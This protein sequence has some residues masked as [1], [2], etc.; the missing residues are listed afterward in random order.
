M[1]G[2]VWAAGLALAGLIGCQSTQPAAGVSHLPTPKLM[3]PAAG[4]ATVSRAVTTTPDS[5]KKEPIKPATL[6]ALGNYRDHLAANPDLSFAEAEQVRSMARAAYNEALKLDPK[7]TAAYLG[8]AKSY[9]AIEDA[10]QAYAMYEKALQQVPE[11]ASLWYEKGL[12]HARFKD[13]P[14]ALAS[15]KR[16]SQIDPDNRLY[17][18]TIG[19]THARMG[20]FEDAY[21]A[22]RGC[23]KEEEVMYTLAR[24]ACH[25]D[26]P[27]V[28]REYL[29]L[30]LKAHPTFMP[31]H[32]MINELN[33]GGRGTGDVTQVDYSEPTPQWT[34]A[35][36]VHVSGVE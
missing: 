24:M 36:K 3:K 34:P 32:Q 16:A 35:P 31:A 29:A 25:L 8:L 2:R 27:D 12:T 15:L 30:A 14:G 17:K 28:G 19:L 5:K 6:V 21:A 4:E 9:V 22:L 23:M 10:A 33:Q 11:D 1:H 7:C 20:D 13:F 18:R 26:R